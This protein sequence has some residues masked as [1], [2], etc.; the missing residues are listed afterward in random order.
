MIVPNFLA[1]S[2]AGLDAHITGHGVGKV[3]RSA[4]KQYLQVTNADFDHANVPPE[5]ALRYNAPQHSTQSPGITMNVSFLE[6]NKNL[7]TSVS[8]LV[9]GTGLE[10]V[11]P[12][13]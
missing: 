12:W 6:G 3:K 1:A 10:P 13:V 9:G 5:K 2:A 8:V 11:T 7:F 4:A